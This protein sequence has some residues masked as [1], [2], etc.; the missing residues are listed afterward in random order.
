MKKFFLFSAWIM[1]IA[2]AG[3]ASADRKQDFDICYKRTEKELGPRSDFNWLQK[4][5]DCA[6]ER[7]LTSLEEKFPSM[8]KASKPDAAESTS[9]DF[10][11]KIGECHGT[12]D[13][14]APDIS[15]QGA[16]V[17]IIINSSAGACSKVTYRL[18]GADQ[19]T[20]VHRAEAAREK[21]FAS[22]PISQD[23]VVVTECEQY[24]AG[25]APVIS[26]N[27]VMKYGLCLGNPDWMKKLDE[28]YATASA[29]IGNDVFTI[30]EFV[31]YF[32]ND[33]TNKF[34]IKRSKLVQ[35]CL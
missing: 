8:M 27:D 9:C 13:V 11:K 7:G 16:G 35:K 6:K 15:S 22:R 14:A 34:W 10:E 4:V 17:E 12:V 18:L 5:W 29:V 20:F 3:P 30:A 26:K 2:M 19:T 28:E 1:T 33:K 25:G 21:V 23:D 31:E 24:E 32:S